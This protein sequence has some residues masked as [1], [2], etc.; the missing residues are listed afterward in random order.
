MADHRHFSKPDRPHHPETVETDPTTRG[1]VQAHRT[2]TSLDQ[3]SDRLEETCFKDELCQVVSHHC[4]AQ[5]MQRTSHFAVVFYL[6]IALLLR[7]EIS[8]LP[9]KEVRLRG[10]GQDIRLIRRYIRRREDRSAGHLR[11]ERERSLSLQHLYATSRSDTH[12]ITNIIYHLP[13]TTNHHHLTATSNHNAPTHPRHRRRNPRIPLAPNI[14]RQHL[15]LQSCFPRQP[16]TLQL[17]TLRHS[18]DKQ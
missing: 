16:L 12:R 17:N 6:S 2:V 13:P 8:R 10:S 18:P 14:R 4:A 3:R 15:F 11:E 7:C 1:P 5:Y 9:K